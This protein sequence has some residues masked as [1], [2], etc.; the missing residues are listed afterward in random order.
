MKVFRWIVLVVISTVIAN[1]TGLAP[2]YDTAIT[3]EGLTVGGGVGYHRYEVESSSGAIHIHDGMEG[4]RPDLAAS[5][6]FTNWFSMTGRVGVIIG[7]DIPQGEPVQE[8]SFGLGVKFS[9]PWK[10]FNISMRVEPDYP[11]LVSLTPMIGFSTRKGHEIVTL[12]LQTAF[13][14][15]PT[16]AFINLHPLSGTHLFAAVG[17]G[18]VCFGLGYAYNFGRKEREEK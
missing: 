13:G 5:Y 15:A 12:G 9:T 17:D 1:C 8:P 16:G 4:V 14:I 10:I 2:I 7:K 18:E 3:H 6:A 11:R